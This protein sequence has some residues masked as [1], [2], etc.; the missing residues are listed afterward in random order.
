MSYTVGVRRDSRVTLEG[1][2]RPARDDRSFLDCLSALHRKMVEAG[3]MRNISSVTVVLHNLSAE[4]EDGK[5][6]FDTGESVKQRVQ[7]ESVSDVIDKIRV[8][9]GSKALN[10]GPAQ[11]PGDYIGS[12]IAFG[13][14]PE[15]EDF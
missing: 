9:H 8:R 14:I 2:F 6:L 13:R 11:G 5:D 12:K 15:P 4:E 10:L 1:E 7:W 3:E